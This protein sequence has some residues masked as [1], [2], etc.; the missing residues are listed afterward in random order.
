M[1]RH[2][3]PS[4][5]PLYRQWLLHS[6]QPIL[7]GPFRGELGFEALYWLPFLA[8]LRYDGVAPERLIPIAR[9]GA[10]CWYDVPHGLEL[11]AMR[12]PQAMRIHNGEQAKRW[13]QLKQTH[14][15]AWDRAVVQDAAQTM[16]L[17]SYLTLHPAWMYQLFMPF[18]AGRAGADLI[19]HHA[20]F[21]ELSPPPLPDGITL[22]EHFIAVKFYARYT[23]PADPHV[24]QFVEQSL[25]QMA[26]AHPVVLLDWDGHVDEHVGFAVPDIP[27]VTRL[28]TLLPSLLPETA[29]AVQSAILARS[30]GF[31]GTYGGFAHLALRFRRPV[32]SYYWEWGGIA[33][34]HRTLSE[35]LAQRM[36]VPFHCLRVLDLAMLQEVMPRVTMQPVARAESQLQAV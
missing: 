11:Y 20:R 8:Q 27:N 33:F 6:K 26:Q 25:R 24:R 35:H 5:W 34:A 28:S 4:L 15:T 17:S 13:G 7:A 3:R 10:A 1:R 18:W 23:F 19:E 12:T 29:L 16:R 22:P 30:M 14:V 31:V 36:G 32:V 21:T 9:A 2:Y